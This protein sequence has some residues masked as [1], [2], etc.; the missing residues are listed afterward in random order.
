M[1]SLSSRMPSSLAACTASIGKPPRAI[2]RQV[3]RL[4]TTVVVAG[5]V[6][7]SAL[8]EALLAG[9]CQAIHSTASLQVVRI[10]LMNGAPCPLG[11]RCCGNHR[12]IGF[13]LLVSS[14]WRAWL[15]NQDLL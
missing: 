2:P 11:W 1:S 6:R 3:A 9:F 15:G 14:R 5:V 8:C 4:A 10:G 12:G 13:D 7:S